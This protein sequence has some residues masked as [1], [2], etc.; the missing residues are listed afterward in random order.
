MGTL[1]HSAFNNEDMQC[2]IRLKR[3][4]APG[5]SGL[6]PVCLHVHVPAYQWAYLYCC[7]SAYTHK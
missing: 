7:V 5:L 2:W 1:F 6:D 4:H 3:V